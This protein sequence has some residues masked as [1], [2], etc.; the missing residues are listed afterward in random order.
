M[1]NVVPSPPRAVNTHIA[2]MEADKVADKRE[3]DARSFMG[4]R[5]VA[6]RTIKALKNAREVCLLYT[7][8][9]VPHGELRRTAFLA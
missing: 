2:A 4:P 1:V 8:A 6:F 7:D 9:S 5:T 3:A